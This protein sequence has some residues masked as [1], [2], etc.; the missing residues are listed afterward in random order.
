MDNLNNI[1]GSGLGIFDP[2]SNFY[3]WDDRKFPIFNKLPQGGH[4]TKYNYTPT[5][6]DENYKE[7]YIENT[8]F[9]SGIDRIATSYDICCGTS[10]NSAY[11]IMKDI[12][13]DA[14]G[15]KFFSKANIKLLQKEIR[16]KLYWLSS[17]R[18]QMECDQE[19]SDLLI[20]MRNIYIQEGRHLPDNIDFQIKKLNMRLLNKILPEMI[21]QIK[22]SYG[23]QKLINEPIQPIDRPMSDTVRGRKLLPSITTIWTK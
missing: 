19:E 20:A 4:L 21:T 8:K 11:Y 12:Q 22:Q 15:L 18:I 5:L 7:K 6:I 3:K 16:N 10:D 13:L 14:L 1:I 17:G 23:Y 2:N 9:T